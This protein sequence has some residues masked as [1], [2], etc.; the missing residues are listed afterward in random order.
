MI[1]YN[2]SNIQ[3]LTFDTNNNMPS[4]DFLSVLKNNYTA[5]EY[6]P[7]EQKIK[8]AVIYKN[9]TSTFLNKNI[10]EYSHISRYLVQVADRYYEYYTSLS[11]IEDSNWDIIFI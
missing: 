5:K 7:L 3:E 2:K 9:H 6:Y 4:Y 1:N 8:E 10:V 11:W